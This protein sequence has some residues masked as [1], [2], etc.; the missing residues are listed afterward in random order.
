MKAIATAPNLSPMSLMA[1]TCV[2][3]MK[4]TT[5]IQIQSTYF[6][7]LPVK[8]W[9]SNQNAYGTA[10]LSVTDPAVSGPARS[11]GDGR[12]VRWAGHKNERDDALL[13]G[14]YRVF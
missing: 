11:R 5:I 10:T 7:V 4:L 3:H 14:P 2:A 13:A 12:G 6:C 1:A 9:P 8:G